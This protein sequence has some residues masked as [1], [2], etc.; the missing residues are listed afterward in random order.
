M[1]IFMISYG[2]G[3]SNIIGEVYKE[4]AKNPDVSITYAALTGAPVKLKGTGIGY[5]TVS[6]LARMLPYRDKVKTLGQKYGVP[7][8]NA[9]F[10]IPMEDTVSYYGI[11]MHDLIEECGLAEAEERFRRMN[12]KAFLP[13][14]TMKELLE[15]I[16]PD[17]CVITASPRMEKA[18]GI[19]ACE[20]HIPVVR[21]NDLPVCAHVDHAC[22][23]CVMNE[24]AKNYAVS[25]ANVPEKDVYVT[26]QPAFDADFSIEKSYVDE[27]KERCGGNRFSKIVTFFAE[28]GADQSKELDALFEI[29]RKMKEVLFVVKLHPNQAL[30]TYGDP[31]LENVY[32]TNADA[33]PYF[34]FSDLAVATFSTTGMESALFGIPVIVI[35]FDGRK[36]LPDYIEMG[37]AVRCDKAENL[38][39]MIQIYLD[40]ESEAYAALKESQGSFQFVR[41][42]AQNIC[43]VIMKAVE[44][45]I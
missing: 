36:Y 5:V 44:E 13:V 25:V 7:Y 6:E 12:R 8:H 2:G 16:S 30:N 20:L 27:M 33:R 42:A 29:A 37:I 24:W 45:A 28:N 11:G 38:G 40:E 21:I 9:S 17:V 18:T 14:K 10:G 19:A 32:I 43:G 41:N 31:Q 4:L 26:G 15:R 22:A 23:L 39:D 35:N 34:H 1:K 3:H